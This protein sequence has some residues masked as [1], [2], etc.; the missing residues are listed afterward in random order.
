MAKQQVSHRLERLRKGCCPV[1]GLFMNQVGNAMQG[2]Q[3]VYVVAC[4]RRD[5]SI[6]GTALETPGAVTLQRIDQHLLRTSRS[7]TKRKSL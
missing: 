3:H 4:P 5:C 2:G 7:L 6:Q 1:H